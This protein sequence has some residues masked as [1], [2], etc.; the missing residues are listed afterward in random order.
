L[1]ASVNKTKKLRIFSN[2]YDYFSISG[3]VEDID[4]LPVPQ[5]RKGF[6]GCISELS[7][8]KLFSIDLLN[9][10]KNGQNVDSCRETFD[11]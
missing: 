3:G 6:V 1:I 8:G 10:A 5:F 4:Q 7:V 9:R 2:T 11:F